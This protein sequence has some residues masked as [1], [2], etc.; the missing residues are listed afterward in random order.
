MTLLEVKGLKAVYGSLEVLHGIDM[1]V[2]KGEIITILGNNA[3][4]KTTLVKAMLGLVRVTAGEVRFKGE[5]ID[6]LPSDQVITRG[7][8]IVPENA[9]VFTT[10]SVL[11]NLKMGF[12]LK[13]RR[14]DIRP[15]LERVIG[16]YPFLTEC[17]NRRADLLSGGQRQMLSVARA[18]ISDPSV[19]I[20]DSPSMGLAPRYVKQQYDTIRKLNRDLGMTV[21]LI[22]Q[23]A[24]MALALCH[25][26]YVLQTGSVALTGSGR[27]LLKNEQ[28]R[29]AYL[30]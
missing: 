8:A 6:G 7:F 21:I 28:M 5:R 24:N 29:L 25:R 20:M 2:E 14:E 13:A 17:L 9:Q 4:G 18:L 22:E 10:L 16:L 12:Y 3:A 15:H 19:L 26:A 11:E 1:S 27:E 23:N 30:T